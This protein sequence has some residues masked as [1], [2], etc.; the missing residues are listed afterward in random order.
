MNGL[1]GVWRR[2]A[3][4]IVITLVGLGVLLIMPVIIGLCILATLIGLCD[5]EA[6]RHERVGAHAR[7]DSL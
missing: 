7:H 5:P 6:G 2:V 4:G 3:I 1:V